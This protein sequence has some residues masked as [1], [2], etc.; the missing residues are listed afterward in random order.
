M[1]KKNSYEAALKFYEAALG[2]CGDDFPADQPMLNEKVSLYC[3]M[4]ET[5]LKIQPA[6]MEQALL[7]ASSATELDPAHSKVSL[8]MHAFIESQL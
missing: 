5:C 4:A 2:V 6:R 8:Q 7:Y 3:K 1:L